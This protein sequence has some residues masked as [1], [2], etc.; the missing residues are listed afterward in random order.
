[1]LSLCSSRNET[2]SRRI[3]WFSVSASAEEKPPTSAYRMRVSRFSVVS[4]RAS[5][6]GATPS[7]SAVSWMVWASAI[8][9]AISPPLIPTSAPSGVS[10]QGDT[11]DGGKRRARCGGLPRAGGGTLG[12][13]WSPARPLL[14]LTLP[15][16]HAGPAP[17]GA[18]RAEKPHPRTPYDVPRG[19]RPLPGDA[20]LQGDSRPRVDARRGAGRSGAGVV[21][22]GAPARCRAARRGAGARRGALRTW[23]RRCRPSRRRARG[24][25]HGRGR[26][27]AAGPCR[28]RR[29]HLP[30]AAAGR[31]RPGRRGA[32]LRGVH[33][34][35]GRVR[36]LGQGGIRHH[37]VRL[38]RDGVLR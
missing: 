17:D 12:A 35:D 22:R 6:V 31:G 8:W 19:S 15:R 30:R 37:G 21:A 24:G 33:S 20:A 4:H 29:A 23:I 27:P 5:A 18:V 3:V 32:L 13:S 26:A 34:T 10:R 36:A 16:S 28:D 2:Y 1:M 38:L 11:G 14:S 9:S 7:A 25:G